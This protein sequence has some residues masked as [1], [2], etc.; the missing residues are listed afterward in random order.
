MISSMNIQTISIFRLS[1]LVGKRKESRLGEKVG[2]KVMS[3][4]SPLLPT[5]M[6]PI[7]AQIVAK[8]MIQAS[9]KELQG[10]RIF[11]YEEMNQLLLN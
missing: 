10:V 8:S 7:K 4:I 9:K 11:H 6:N 1:F 5:K 2:I 3:S